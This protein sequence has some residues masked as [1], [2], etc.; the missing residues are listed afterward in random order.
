MK[1]GQVC[2]P[3]FGLCFDAAT[4]MQHMS[5]GKHHSGLTK[6][7][8]RKSPLGPAVPGEE[9]THWWLEDEAGDVLD[10]TAGQFTFGAE[11]PYDKREK[12][13]IGFPYFKKGGTNYSELVPPR[14]VVEFAEAFKQW[15]KQEHGEETAFGMDWWLEEKAR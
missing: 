12:G 10:P 3:S 14:K 6:K 15:H 9:S 11:P 1:G 2:H 4:L 5:G 13:D 8:A 7:R